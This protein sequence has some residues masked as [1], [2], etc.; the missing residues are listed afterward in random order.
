MTTE[1]QI[2]GADDL[3]RDLNRLAAPAGPFDQST[4][5]AADRLLEPRAATT[6]SA[7]PRLSGAMAGSINVNPQPFGAVLSEGD[8]IAYAGWVDF[9][10][11]RPQSGPREYRPDG[12]YL[13]PSV[14][15]L[16]S[17]TA[18]AYTA[19]LQQTIDRYGWTF[20]G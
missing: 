17:P 15:D 11:Q 14:G 12:R 7:V 20:K 18:A 9:G 5:T 2:I 16:G 10:G 1:V 13:F 6:R 8:G 19:A 4:R 3:V